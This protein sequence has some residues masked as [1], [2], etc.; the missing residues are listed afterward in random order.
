[1]CRLRT[2]YSLSFFCLSPSLCP[3]L[4]RSVIVLFPYPSVSRPCLRLSLSLSPVPVSR[5]RPCLCLSSLSLRFSTSLTLSPPSPLL[6]PRQVLFAVSAWRRRTR[7][8]HSV[9]CRKCCFPLL[10]SVPASRQ[11]APPLQMGKLPSSYPTLAGHSRVVYDTDWCVPRISSLT[12]PGC[13]PCSRPP[14]TS[15]EPVQRQHRRDGVRRLH[16]GDLERAGRRL[17]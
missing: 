16:G 3:S 6:H 15:Q 10:L 14:P 7:V 9:L 1:M 8:R 2:S 11:P 5:L 17:D 12:F 4:C 13:Y